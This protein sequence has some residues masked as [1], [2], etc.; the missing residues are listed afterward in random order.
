MKETVFIIGILILGGFFLVA[1]AFLFSGV[2]IPSFG[3]GNI[4]NGFLVEIRKISMDHPAIQSNAYF[5]LSIL[6]TLRCSFIRTALEELTTSSV[7]SYSD[8]LDE[9]E[10]A[11]VFN[12][13]VE[14]SN[15]DPPFFAFMHENAYFAIVF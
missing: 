12:L 15:Q 1:F 3:D 11:C 2:G 10:R 14:K 4:D 7:N 8:M 13:M 5:N 9:G 6:E